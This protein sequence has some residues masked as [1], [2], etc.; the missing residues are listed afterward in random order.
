MLSDGESELLSTGREF[1]VRFGRSLWYKLKGLVFLT[2]LLVG[3]WFLYRYRASVLSAVVEH[4]TELIALVFLNFAMIA[5]QAANFLNLLD[6]KGS[7]SYRKTLYTWALGGLVNYLG[8]LQPGL[9]LRI[10]LFKLQGVT[11]GRSLVTTVKQL[12]LSIWTGVAIVGLALAF[13]P[14]VEARWAGVTLA[15]MATLWVP[16][17]SLV[18]NCLKRWRSPVRWRAGL[19]QAVASGLA[20]PRFV[21]LWYFLAQHSIA[22]LAVLIV[23]RGFGAG[24]GMGDAYVIAV[25]AT[26]SGLISLTPNNLGLQELILGYAAWQGGLGVAD[27]TAI[28]ALFRIAHVLSCAVAVGALVLLPAPREEPPMA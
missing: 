6:A 3:A 25:V 9:A 2:A 14:R 15:L 27:A 20:I 4:R 5:V 23:Y 7:L 1:P 11:A 19:V 24:I 8:P 22:A 16:A 28:A 12:H 26:L 13:R 10:A 18:H 17:A 21:D